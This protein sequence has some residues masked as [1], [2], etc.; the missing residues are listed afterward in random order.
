LWR[1]PDDFTLHIDLPADEIQDIAP[2]G[3]LSGHPK[4]VSRAGLGCRAD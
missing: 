1:V 4:Y 3:K 2:I